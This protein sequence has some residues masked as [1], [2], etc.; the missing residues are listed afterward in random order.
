M[1]L[2]TKETAVFILALLIFNII[3][4][5]THRAQR[6]DLDDLTAEVAELRAAAERCPE[7]GGNE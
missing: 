6:R 4:G 2:N 7:E 3:D 1:S 5:F